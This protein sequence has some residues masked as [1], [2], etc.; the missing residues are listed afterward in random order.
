MQVLELRHIFNWILPTSGLSVC[1]ATMLL[2]WGSSLILFTCKDKVV[3][4]QN[5]FTPLH[6]SGQEQLSK[7]KLRGTRSKH[8]EPNV[9]QSSDAVEQ[10][11][12]NIELVQNPCSIQVV[13]ND[14]K[15][16]LPFD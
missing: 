8:E 6:I 10:V 9:F 15:K 11:I 12:M 13:K 4:F 7:R 1:V 14:A 16:H 3:N 2:F 5:A